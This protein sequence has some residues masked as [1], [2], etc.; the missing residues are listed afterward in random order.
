[1]GA[2]LGDALGSGVGT[3]TVK[4]VSTTLLDVTVAGVLRVTVLV[5]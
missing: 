4:K 5:V 2:L 3:P 1:M